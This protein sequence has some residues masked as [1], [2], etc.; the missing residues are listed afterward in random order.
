M[1][2]NN[3]DSVT[4]KTF[5]DCTT[6]VEKCLQQHNNAVPGGPR[7]TRKGAG[8]WKLALRIVV[9]RKRNLANQAL[10]E[11]WKRN[12][13]KA[14]RRLEFGISMAKSLQLEWFINSD[15]FSDKQVTST[16]RPIVRAYYSQRRKNRNGK[17]DQILLKR[18]QEN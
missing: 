10:V 16:I 17:V 11:F 6:D 3:S 15:L 5:I 2:V 9:P 1:I 12:S 7:V 18:F 8:H 14:N 13:R 4:T